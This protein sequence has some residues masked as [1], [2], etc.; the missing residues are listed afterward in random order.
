[1]RALKPCGGTAEGMTFSG[2]VNHH[3]PG[4]SESENFSQKSSPILWHLSRKDE[5]FRNSLGNSSKHLSNIAVV[6]ALKS[7]EL[8]FHQKAERRGQDGLE[9]AGDQI[10]PWAAH[11][12]CR[13]PGAGLVPAGHRK[14]MPWAAA[15]ETPVGHKEKVLP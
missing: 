11:K 7:T 10:T 8:A 6:F 15:R 9:A 3:K 4:I 14:R 1:M 12:G 13:D 2:A 5:R